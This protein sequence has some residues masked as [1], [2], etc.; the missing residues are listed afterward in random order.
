[1]DAPQ[2]DLK[3]DDH[4]RTTVYKMEEYSVIAIQVITYD[5]N[6]A[7]TINLRYNVQP[8]TTYSPI[9]KTPNN[10]FNT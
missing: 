1:M 7:I 8:Y 3:L 5:T 6:I 4:D 10:D 9:K 2:F